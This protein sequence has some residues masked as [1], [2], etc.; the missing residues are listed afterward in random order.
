MSYKLYDYKVGSLEIEKK[1]G[2]YMSHSFYQE[3]TDSESLL[4]T[5]DTARQETLTLQTVDNQR[6]S[7]EI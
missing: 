6:V 5:K 2:K 4:V 3:Y 7:G 1:Y